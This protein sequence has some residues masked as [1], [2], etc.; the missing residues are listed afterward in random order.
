MN[1]DDEQATEFLAGRPRA[2][3]PAAF[4]EIGIHG[5]GLLTFA[6]I[7][8]KGPANGS[9]SSQNNGGTPLTSAKGFGVQ[10]SIPLITVVL[11]HPYASFDTF[12]IAAW[13]ARNFSRRP[14]RSSSTKPDRD[15]DRH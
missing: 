7:I 13:P 5:S 3:P 11:V 15:L 2:P 14:R 4:Q 6:V 9:F 12:L 1:L 10:I 8:L